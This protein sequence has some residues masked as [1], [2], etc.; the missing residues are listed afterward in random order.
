MESNIINNLA[1]S[2]NFLENINPKTLNECKTEFKK[3]EKMAYEGVLA[4]GK[5]AYICKTKFYKE[6]EQNFAL[7]CEEKLSYKLKTVKNFIR[8]YEIFQNN[9]IDY[10]NI[11]KKL[12]SNKLG[13]IT[14][15]CEYEYTYYKDGKKLSHP[16]IDRYEDGRRKFNTSHMESFIEQNKDNLED[17]TL[18]DLKALVKEYKITNDLIKEKKQELKESEQK[19]IDTYKELETV[20]AETD[21]IKYVQ[22]TIGNIV[23]SSN[24]LDIL[25]EDDYKPIIQD[26]DMKK[27]LEVNLIHIRDKINNLLNEINLEK[28]NY[29]NII[30]IENYTTEG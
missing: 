23:T 1:N 4:M 6:D 5:I 18:Q 26:V 10:G 19:L 7:W 27:E 11:L 8:Y 20:S 25:F 3:A 12:S 17:I 16:I 21:K 24:K 15:L 29:E 22:S 14:S 9:D 30:D 28:Y 13:A 2:S